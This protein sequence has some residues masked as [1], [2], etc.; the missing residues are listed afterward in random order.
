MLN[1]DEATAMI[2]AEISEDEEIAGVF[3][4]ETPDENGVRRFVWRI[5]GKGLQASASR[6]S[7][8]AAQMR[9]VSKGRNSIQPG[10]PALAIGVRRGVM[11]PVSLFVAM[12]GRTAG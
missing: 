3:R 10:L 6:S 7:T 2:K 5:I 4:C 1:K 12:G 9:L 8:K 11:L